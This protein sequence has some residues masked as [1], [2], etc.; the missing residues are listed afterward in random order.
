MNSNSLSEHPKGLG[1]PIYQL[2]L[3]IIKSQKTFRLL[4]KLIYTGFYNLLSQCCKFHNNW[5]GSFNV[6]NV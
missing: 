4:R 2:K 6:P 3:N 1:R 5:I